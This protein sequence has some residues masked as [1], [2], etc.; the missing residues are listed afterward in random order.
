MGPEAESV[1]AGLFWK[2]SWISPYSQERKKKRCNKIARLHS[3][4]LKIKNGVNNNHM[5]QKVNTYVD[6]GLK[7]KPIKIKSEVNEYKFHY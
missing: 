6:F 7:R 5:W 2:C 4:A 3:H 1:T